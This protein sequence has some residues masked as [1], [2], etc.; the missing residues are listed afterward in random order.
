MEAAKYF[1]TQSFQSLQRSTNTTSSILV[2]ASHRTSPDSRAEEGRLHLLLEEG[3]IRMQGWKE[4]GV[5]IFTNNPLHIDAPIP[6]T[7]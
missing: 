6:I 2:K 1:Q 5:A 4:F 3:G 7:V